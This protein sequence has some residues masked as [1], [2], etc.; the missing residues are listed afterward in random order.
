MNQEYYN[1]ILEENKLLKQQLADLQRSQNSI[2]D[3]I[4]KNDSIK[5]LLLLINEYSMDLMN[6]PSDEVFVTGLQKLTEFIDAKSV[7]Y[8]IYDPN[9]KELVVQHTSLSKTERK[10]LKALMGRDIIGMRVPFTDEHLESAMNDKVHIAYSVHELSLG[11][12]PKAVGV[13]IEETFKVGWF[14]GIAMIH[15]EK[16]LGTFVIVGKKAVPIPD[17][18]VLYAFAGVTANALIRKQA[19]ESL[20]K[21]QQR[22]KAYLDNSPDGIFITNYLGEI[23]DVNPAGAL[24][25]GKDRGELIGLKVSEF[26]LPEYMADVDTNVDSL[27]V[28]GQVFRDTIKYYRNDNLI[29]T[30]L[31]STARIDNDLYASFVKNIDDIVEA[32][33]LL[34]KAKEKAEESDRL[35]SAFLAN[36]SH[37][38]RSPMNGILGFAN[39]LKTRDAGY[40][41]TQMFLNLI[42]SNGNQLL[43]LIDD[44]LDIAKLEAK[45]LKIQIRECN[46]ASIIDEVFI[47][48]QPKAIEKEIQL[49]KKTNQDVSEFVMYSDCLRIKQ[50]ITNLVTNAIK[51]THEGQVVISYSAKKS[52]F[53]IEVKDTGIGIPKQHLENIFNRFSQVENAQ[54]T[55]S[56]GTGLGLAITKGLVKL[57]N[58]RISVSS[59]PNI[60]SSFVVSL[61]IS[62]S[63]EENA[64]VT[65]PELTQKIQNIDEKIILVCEDEESNYLYISELLNIYNYKH[66]RASNGNQAVKMVEEN[67]NIGLILMD[68]KMP[69]LNGC[70]ATKIIKEKKPNIPVIANSAFIS[71]HVSFENDDC[72]FDELII[73]PIVPEVLLKTIKKYFSI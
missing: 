23:L 61:P 70:E 2:S 8:S 50:I 22:M 41:K 27:V 20:I 17:K 10:V 19:D 15:K 43:M 66:I 64:D 52:H 24:L 37:E 55:S 51:F 42:T 53:E 28:N 44:L 68:I 29:S 14:L 73:K 59:E 63:E 3:S 1:K 11:K 39:L 18:E 26:I 67:E 6:V 47:Q 40:E 7:H 45:Q 56:S 60:G 21:S 49:I 16:F 9:T 31:I 30:A 25:I 32:K 46:L 34:F 38:I 54:Y 33:D 62:H 57:L 13:I 58:G 12:V 5:N 65:V 69:E 72:G 71:E 36:I 35:K 48:Y 4:Y